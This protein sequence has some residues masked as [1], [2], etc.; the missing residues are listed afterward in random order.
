MPTEKAIEY[1]TYDDY[2]H[3][4]GKW[5][6]IG[7]IPMAMPPSP[8]IKHQAIAAK[9]LNEIMNSIERL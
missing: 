8:V 9:I 5:E 7:G 2:L 3:W 1:Y 4:E 6:L